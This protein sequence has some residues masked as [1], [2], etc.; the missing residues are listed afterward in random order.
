MRF[1]TM[2]QVLSGCALPAPQLPRLQVLLS[3]SLRSAALEVQSRSAEFSR[4]FK[5]EGGVR[6]QVPGA[7]NCALYIVWY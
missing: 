5:L 4:V 7:A 3:K 1:K 2:R 6:A